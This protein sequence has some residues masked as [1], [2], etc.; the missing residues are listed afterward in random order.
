MKLRKYYHVYADGKTVKEI[1]GDK[2][3]Y[4][5]RF[6]KPSLVVTVYKNDVSFGKGNSDIYI[7]KKQLMKIL[8]DSS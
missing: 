7:P 4:N 3:Y 5:R 6:K 2:W 1:K 8:G